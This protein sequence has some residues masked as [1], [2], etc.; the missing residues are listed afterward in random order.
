MWLGTCAKNIVLTCSA[1]LATS[2][3]IAPNRDKNYQKL[4]NPLNEVGV[5]CTFVSFFRNSAHFY[6]PL[7]LNFNYLFYV[8]NQIGGTF[9]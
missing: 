1:N 5:C 8:K 9:P 3:Q 7:N 4:P 2:Y 6:E